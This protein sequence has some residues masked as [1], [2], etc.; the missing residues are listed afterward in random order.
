MTSKVVFT[1]EGKK[2]YGERKLSEASS[3]TVQSVPRP[4]T[5]DIDSA[6]DPCKKINKQLAENKNNLLLIDENIY[7]LYKDRLHLSKEKT[8]IAKAT[9]GFKNID[10]VMSVVDFLQKNAMTKGEKLIVV[11]GGII[12]DVG[13]FV[14]VC[15]KRG[16]PWVYFPTT[17]LS[18]CDSCIGGKAGINHGHAKNQLA[19]FSAP[20]RVIIN[21]RF[22]LTLPAEAIDSGMGEVLKLFIIGGGPYVDIFNRYTVNGKARSFS[23]YKPLILAALSVKKAVIEVDEFELNYRR[24]LNYGHTIGH[25]VEVLSGYRIP[26]GQA[27]SMGAIIVNAL[28]A[29]RSLLKNAERKKLNTLLFSLISPR[30]LKKMRQIKAD[31]IGELFKKD[32]KTLGNTVNIAII[33]K[34]GDTR[35]LPLLIDAQLVSE[36]EHIMQE[37]FR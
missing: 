3:F 8:Y 36:I 28:S 37:E 4:Y 16:I 30:I 32:K 15:Y 24:S 25:A 19:L 12:Q 13:A 20:S 27:V 34:A 22:L 18:M 5:V 26:H 33:A 31:T 23:S 29:R 14:G 10:G 7:K 1:I 9:E 2:F 11:G 6:A 17:L 21:P 35:I